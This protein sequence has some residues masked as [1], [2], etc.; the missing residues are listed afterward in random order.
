MKQYVNHTITIDIPEGDDPL[1]F[2]HD[3][4]HEALCV[5]LDHIIEAHT[6]P[7]SFINSMSYQEACRIYK[8]N[9]EDLK[10]QNVA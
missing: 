6:K 5:Q 8:E 2:I 3:A 10:R 9:V 7:D 4:L 1:E